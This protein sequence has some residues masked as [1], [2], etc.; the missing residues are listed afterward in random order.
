MHLFYHP[1]ID[2]QLRELR[3]LLVV[4]SNGRSVIS[5]G[6]KNNIEAMVVTAKRLQRKAPGIDLVDI[7]SKF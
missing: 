6:S 1:K 2:L 3:G 5:K 4:L 7:P